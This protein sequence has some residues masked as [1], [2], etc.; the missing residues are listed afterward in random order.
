MLGSTALKALD[1]YNTQKK[2]GKNPVFK[3]ASM[4]LTQKTDF[5][6]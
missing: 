4:G 1:D 6:N 2:R 5:W 3:A